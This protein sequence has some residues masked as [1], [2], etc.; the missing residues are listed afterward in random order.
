M[1]CTK[2]ASRTAGNDSLPRFLSS[3]K[4]I[5]WSQEDILIQNW[6]KLLFKSNLTDRLWKWGEEGKKPPKLASVKKIQGF[7]FQIQI[8]VFFLLAESEFCSQKSCCE[9]E[10][11][12][13]Q[14]VLPSMSK[15]EVSEVLLTAAWGS[16]MGLKRQVTTLLPESKQRNKIRMHLCRVTQNL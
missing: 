11:T 7:F 14:L 3:L 16:Y 12:L 10:L 13:H 6:I 4:V 1:R 15:V 8:Q 2:C 9:G 5:D